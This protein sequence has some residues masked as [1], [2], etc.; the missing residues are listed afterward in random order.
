MV[1]DFHKSKERYFEIQY[2]N[3]KSHVLPFVEQCCSVGEGVR[4]LEIGSAEGGVLKAFTEK[5]CDCV[6]IEL[7]EDRVRLAEKFMA[8]EVDQNK[9]KFVARNI[10]DID[11]VKSPEFRFDVIL[12]KDVIEHIH[13]QEKFMVKLKD[14]MRPGA[15]VFFGFPPWCMPYGGHQQIANNKIASRLPYYHLLPMSLYKGILKLFGETKE[16]VEGL[17]E[18]KETKIGLSR[19][20][21]LCRKNNFAVAARKLYLVRPIYQY[22]F[23]AKIREQFPWLTGIPYVRDFFTTAGFYLIRNKNS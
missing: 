13:D 8:S 23:N 6:G 19:F 15:H 21:Y 1:Y 10:F 14:F 18:I 16:K 3:S 2:L 22:K 17:A 5:G 12:L 11:P 9:V 7:S 4:V 20:E